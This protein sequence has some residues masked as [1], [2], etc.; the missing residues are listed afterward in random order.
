MKIKESDLRSA[1]IDAMNDDAEDMES[2]FWNG[3]NMIIAFLKN[4]A[5][6]ID[7][8][9]KSIISKMSTDNTIEVI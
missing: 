7:K 3:A 1:I 2:V 8:I 4:D 9:K 6:E 5:Y